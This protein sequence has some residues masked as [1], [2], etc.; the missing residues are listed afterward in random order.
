MVATVHM[1]LKQTRKP[2]F[3][4]RRDV[5]L[6]RTDSNMK[7]R[8]MVE[9][10]NR[11]EEEMEMEAEQMWEH[12]ADALRTSVEAVVLTIKRRNLG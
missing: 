1:K 10:H 12:L 2:N 3:E 8:Y 7:R 4:P 5:E 9:V 6:L 11:Y